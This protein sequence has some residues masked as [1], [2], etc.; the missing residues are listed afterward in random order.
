MA[1]A[2]ATRKKTG[3]KPPTHYDIG[4]ADNVFCPPII[5]GY[6]F[7]CFPIKSL[8]RVTLVGCRNFLGSFWLF[9]EG[10]HVIKVC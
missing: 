1:Y 4:W 5:F 8:Q 10:D 3:R 7:T 2:A 9:C 6:M